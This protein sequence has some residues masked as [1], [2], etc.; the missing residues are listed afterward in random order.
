[1][2]RF[3]PTPTFLKNSKRLSKKYPSFKEDLRLFMESL[4]ENPEQGVLLADNFRKI[5]MAIKSKGK[6]KRGGARVITLN[7]L[8]TF[9]EGVVTLVSIYDKSDLEN[10]SM[11]EIRDAYSSKD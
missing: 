4:S 1:M 10:M 6:G 11:A 8:V 9:G 5:R 7:C 3:E 2:I